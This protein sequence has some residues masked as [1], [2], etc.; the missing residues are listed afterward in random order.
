MVQTGKG[1]D[2]KLFPYFRRSCFSGI[3]CELVS[4]CF[5]LLCGYLISD[6]LEL[7]MAGTV[8]ELYQKA[9]YAVCALVGAI[10]PKYPLILL[11]SKTRLEDTQHF[12]EFLYQ[13]LLRREI[14]AADRGEMTVRMNSDT[15]TIAAFYQETVPKAV[16]G[17]LVMLCSAILLLAAD[18]RIGAIFFCLNLTQLIP[19]LVYEKWTRQIY[20]QTHSDEEDYCAWM[21]EGYNGI[22]TIKA[23]GAQAWFME[24]YWKLNRAIVSSGKRAEQ[25]GTVERVIFSAIDSLLN[26][27]SYLI[28][29]LFVL[30]GGLEMSDTPILIILSRYLFSSISS[31]FDLRLQQFQ[32]QEAVGRLGFRE[33]PK[34]NQSGRALLTVRSISK[35]YGDK[36]V[37][38]G[39][40]CTIHQ[41]E[42]VHLTGDNGSGKTTLLQ[43]ILGLEDSDS[44]EVAWSIPPQSRAVSLQEEPELT[45]IANELI[46]AMGQNIDPEEMKTHLRAF[47]IDD[48][49]DRP[50]NQLSPGERKKFY[51]SAVLSHKGEL[52][53]LD[54]PTNHLDRD[55]VTYLNRVLAESSR[56]MII[57]T[58]G[59]GLDLAWSKEIRMEGGI[60]H[61][62]SNV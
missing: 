16:S 1:T 13:A 19:I 53:I 35:S 4:Y 25:V 43:I 48:L 11:R 42:R 9:M 62:S 26:Y 18:W 20:N 8:S 58:H 61:E 31:V 32:Y 44:G 33:N 59:S 47:R 6:L 17:V 37:L 41:G 56:T 57:C 46:H 51:L 54:E 50:L 39:A 3:T 40:S 29:G 34:E 52:L 23:Y 5:M 45:A 27:G 49:C 28:I 21:L 30:Y 12:R 36:Q 24:R 2:M 55:S 10:L 22:E 14:Q 38:S 60:C 7:V 15:R